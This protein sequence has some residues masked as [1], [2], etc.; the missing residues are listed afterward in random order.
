[1][2]FSETYRHKLFLIIIIIPFDLFESVASTNHS[3]SVHSNTGW[4]SCYMQLKIA[5]GIQN[6]SIWIIEWKLSWN[7]DTQID[8][9]WKIT[10]GRKKSRPS[11][12][13]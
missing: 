12:P 3:T 8:S 9:K 11:R 7:C 4:H 2:F 10:V 13:R 1:M 6:D 5:K